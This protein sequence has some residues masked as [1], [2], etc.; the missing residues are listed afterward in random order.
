MKRLVLDAGPLIA[1][2]SKKD[3]YHSEAKLGFSKI[4]L[5][6]GEVLT[7]LPI[8]FEV[9]KFVSRNESINM[10]KK[11]LSVI[12]EETVIVTISTSDFVSISDLVLNFSHWRGTLE[13]ASVIVIAQKY[14][15]Q[16][17]TIDYKDLGFFGSME[18]WNP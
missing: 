15:S 14:Q 9:Y 8:L 11:L 4:S 10:A 17:W 2:V 1:L 13:D 6:F 3:N 5:I 16:I 18:F 7:P 12:E